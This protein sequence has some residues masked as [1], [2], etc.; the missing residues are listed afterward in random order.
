[1]KIIP[2]CC[3]CTK[4]G[5]LI[6]TINGYVCKNHACCHSKQEMAFP[7]VNSIP[8]LISEIQTDTVCSIEAG[9]TYFKRP[10]AKY[11]KLKKIIVGESKTTKQN[12]KKFLE[13]VFKLT[14]N[15]KA[16]E[17]EKYRE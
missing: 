10:M 11:T 12:C 15:P 5:E 4:K 1:M 6:E 13:E 9:K 8:I 17:N 7:K 14:I 16:M 3:P 2:L